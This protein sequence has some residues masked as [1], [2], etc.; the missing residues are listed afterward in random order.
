MSSF[1]N[2]SESDEY[3]IRSRSVYWLFAAAALQQ[4]LRPAAAVAAVPAEAPEV[5]VEGQQDLAKFL[6]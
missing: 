3:D 6:Q 4:L 2:L 1:R 5:G